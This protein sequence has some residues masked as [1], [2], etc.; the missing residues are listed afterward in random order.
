[1]AD[2]AP[3]KQAGNRDEFGRFIKGQT[4]NPKGRPPVEFSPTQL[5]RA[6]VAERPKI[7]QRI[8][9]LCES[10]DENVAIKALTYVV[11]RL[12]GM[13]KQA[14]DMTYRQDEQ[15]FNA[16]IAQFLEADG[17]DSG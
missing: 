1:M 15:Q 14:M 13:P 2:T 3:A 16:K 8:L 11:N 7:I 5:L 4:G 10:E 17:S 6:A 9:A 12:D